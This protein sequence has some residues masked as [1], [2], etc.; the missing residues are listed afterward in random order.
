MSIHILVPEEDA[1]DIYRSL[2]FDNLSSE[3]FDST[4]KACKQYRF[5][6]LKTLNSTADILAKWPFYKCPSGFRLV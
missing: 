3:V 4:W 1:E 2:K 6:D 5:N